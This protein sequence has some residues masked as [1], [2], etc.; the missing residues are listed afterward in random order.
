[1]QLDRKLPP[2]LSSGDRIALVAPARFA[3]AELIQEA[4]ESISEAGFKPLIYK[5]L[6]SRENQFGGTDE[7]RA[8]LLNKAFRDSSVRAVFAL[9]GGYGTGRVLPLLDQEAFTSDPKWIIGFSDITALHAWA[10]NLGVASIHAPLASTLS[11]TEA[12]DVASLWS[13]LKGEKV[14]PLVSETIVGG[15]L[16]VLYS[17]MG[18][19]FFPNLDECTLL[20]EDLDEFLYHIDRMMLALRLSG[21]FNRV[22]G[23]ILGGFSDLKDNTKKHGQNVDN[24]FGR[25]IDQ[26]LT[27]HLPKDLSV[28]K[29]APSGHGVRNFPVVLGGP[30]G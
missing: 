15:N 30:R 7:H 16:S 8:E 28:I 20:L 18:T 4:A 14:K 27:D 13:T 29:N 5:G 22:S 23:L 12:S 19:P 3:S 2:Y 26:I 17:L 21:A 6:E 9:R 25:S 1:M 11:T 24:P 10:N